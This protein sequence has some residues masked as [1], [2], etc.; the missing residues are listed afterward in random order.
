MN[1]MH[2]ELCLCIARTILLV[3]VAMF[4]GKISELLNLNSH[5]HIH[6]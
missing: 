2:E 6:V 1:R 5:H 3:F 4:S